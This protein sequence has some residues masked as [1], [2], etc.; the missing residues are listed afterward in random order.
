VSVEKESRRALR[1]VVFWRL[2]GELFCIPQAILAGLVAV[3]MGLGNWL[4]GVEMTFFFYEL[5]SARRYKLLTD[6]DLGAASNAPGRYGFALHPDLVD[7]SQ[8][9]FVKEQLM[10]EGDDEDE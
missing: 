8:R 1:R 9:D 6:M 10:V 5:D 4:K 2:V 3:G 7:K